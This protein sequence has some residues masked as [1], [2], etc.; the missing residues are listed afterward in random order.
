MDQTPGHDYDSFVVRLWRDAT[1]R[2]LLR[3]EVEHVQS[4]SV[5]IS[6]GATWDW[7]AE[8]LRTE[9][10][11][12]VADQPSRIGERAPAAARCRPVL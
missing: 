5:G 6:V 11:R 7:L 12:N 3:A 10:Q 8:R 2:A 1:T 4:G 9:G